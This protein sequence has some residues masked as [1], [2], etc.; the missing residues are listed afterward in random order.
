L[1]LGGALGGGLGALR[2]AV[3]RATP[4]LE[5]AANYEAYKALGRPPKA[6]SKEAMLRAG[7]VENVGAVARKYGLFGDTLGEATKVE[8]AELVERAQKA[9]SQVG[10]QMNEITEKTGATVDVAP[11]LE[12]L[13]K[14]IAEESQTTIGK[15]SARRLQAY[16]DDL[17]ADL[18][19]VPKSER[20]PRTGEEL[21]E[22]MRK[23][24]DA[25]AEWVASGKV[26]DEAAFREVTAPVETNVPIGRI[27]AERRSLGAAAF[28][29]KLAPTDA[30]TQHLQSFYGELSTFEEKALDDASKQ[31][32]RAD[33]QAFKALKKDYQG[34]KLIEKATQDRA[35]AMAT[36]ATWPLTAKIFAA[37]EV[38]GSIAHG[39]P[40]E[41]L[42]AIPA[43]MAVKFI[44]E[45]GAAASQHV[46]GKI[47]T[48][49]HVARATRMVDSELEQSIG[50]MG[51]RVK[52]RIRLRHFSGPD[53]SAHPD[54]KSEYAH[55]AAASASV[56]PEE[57]SQAMPSLARGAPKTSGSMVATV[58]A[59]AQY[60]QANRPAPLNGPSLI[61]PMA[62]PRYS[63]VETE[64]FFERVRAVQDPVG[65]LCEAIETGMIGE[66]EIDAVKSVYPNLYADM[67]RKVLEEI[68][69]PR[70]KPIDYDKAVAVAKIFGLPV[71]P[72][73]SPE[74]V[75]LFQQN[76]VPDQGGP[77]SA[78]KPRGKP[79]QGLE[80]PHQDALARAA[81]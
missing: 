72:T 61:D 75:R 39:H 9:L 53:D 68:S 80:K 7:G 28:P 60:L 67:Q 78:P 4:G 40:L 45:H 43:G 19:A 74:S 2:E 81:Q 23:N 11:V 65:T 21:Q 73:T 57:F 6:V 76:Y 33:G 18:G 35:A 42:A 17:A 41:A 14:R 79:V 71:D 66:H 62:K 26:P 54:E 1:V 64:Q 27:I 16:R 10:S 52:P 38:A 50:V 51:G 29:G 15:D 32:G 69:S 56:K 49:D 58:N 31:M 36:N 77:P 3:S 13:D 47:S 24:P 37:A 8:P 30:F 63:E 59:G 25:A 5:R 44:Q 70:E 48:L 55:K 34:L 22:Y 46:L 12:S 20:V